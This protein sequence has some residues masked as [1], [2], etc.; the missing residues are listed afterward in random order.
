MR[1]VERD[2]E[3]H[4]FCYKFQFNKDQ[5]TIQYFSLNNLIIECTAIV[6][7]ERLRSYV[8]CVPTLVY[9]RQRFRYPLPLPIVSPYSVTYQSFWTSN[10]I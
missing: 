4:Y 5:F 3:L 1:N 6:I 7:N 8:E 9:I 2:N 10:R